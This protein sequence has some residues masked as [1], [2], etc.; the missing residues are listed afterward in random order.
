MERRLAVLAW[1]GND[2]FLRA[3]LSETEQQWLAQVK[4]VDR[5]A[6]PDELRH[7]L[8]EWL[9]QIFPAAHGA[10]FWPPAQA[11]KTQSGLEPRGKTLKTQPEE[12]RGGLPPAAPAP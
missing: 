9:A 11:M 4:S 2:G 6:L 5:S 8:P 7:N 12:A 10:E 1:R 3:A